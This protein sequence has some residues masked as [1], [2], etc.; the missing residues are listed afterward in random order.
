[1]ALVRG[2][3]DEGFMANLL[4]DHHGKPQRP[5]GFGVT[6]GTAEVATRFLKSQ[7]FDVPA[8]LEQ[9]QVQENVAITVL[10]RNHVVPNME[11]MMMRDV[12]YPCRNLGYP[13]K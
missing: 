10:D 4:L 3:S 6:A 9:L 1:M 7:G 2:P 11:P 5:L 8:R 13:P 12:C